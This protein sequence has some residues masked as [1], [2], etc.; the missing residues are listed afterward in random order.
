MADWDIKNVIDYSPN[1]D[2]IDTFSQKVKAEEGVIY[3]RL[4]RV[5]CNDASAGVLLSDAVPYQWHIDTST[6]PA[7]IY[8]YDGQTNAWVKIGTVATAFGLNTTDLGGI[9]NEGGITTMQMGKDAEKPDTAQ[10]RA[11]YFA[12]DAKKIYMWSGVAWDVF[13]SLDYDDIIDEEGSAVRQDDVAT[14]GANKIARFDAD[15]N[16]DSDITGSPARIVN[17]G[18]ETRNLG[19]GDALVYNGTKWVNQKVPRMDD[20]GTL[21]VNISGNAAKVGGVT[22]RTDGNLNDGQILV[23][24]AATN[25][26]TNENK[27]TIGAGAALSFQQ[28]GEEIMSYDGSEPKTLEFDDFAKEA[29][30]VGEELPDPNPIHFVEVQA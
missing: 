30:G 10:L 16:L 3:E 7:T 18:I 11:L 2:D 1:G 17:R 22:I 6:E 25:T 26:F 4:N 8:M 24:R 19:E 27:G 28:H 5:R 12:Y 29:I 21:D 13:L 20:S 23:F 15:G 9:T 14:S